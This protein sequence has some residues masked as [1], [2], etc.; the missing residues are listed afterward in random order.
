MDVLPLSAFAQH[1]S[2]EKRPITA[3]VVFSRWNAID[4]VFIPFPSLL[5]KAHG[6]TSSL[7]SR[8]LWYVNKP[9]VEACFCGAQQNE[10]LEI[11]GE[12]FPARA[13]SE[14]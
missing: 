2:L 6:P 5:S 7:F 13:D 9:R 1:P 11:P 8:S 4:L 10:Y 3:D 14:Y 12:T